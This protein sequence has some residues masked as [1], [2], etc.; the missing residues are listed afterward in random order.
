MK[1]FG[2]GTHALSGGVAVALLAQ[3]PRTQ[4]VLAVAAE[5]DHH[6]SRQ[7]PATF[8]CRRDGRP[9]NARSSFIGSSS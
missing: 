7:A 4:S 8:T 2:I 3:L 5:A 1:S 9:A 6:T